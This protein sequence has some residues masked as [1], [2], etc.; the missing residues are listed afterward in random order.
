MEYRIQLAVNETN[1]LVKQ[2]SQH[3]FAKITHVPFAE[4]RMNIAAG[5]CFRAIVFK[6]NFI[7]SRNKLVQRRF[8]IECF[9]FFDPILFEISLRNLIDNLNNRNESLKFTN[10]FSVYQLKNLRISYLEEQ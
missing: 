6:L 4:Q 9:S 5:M 8:Q 1:V 7:Y 2:F 10:I 3:L